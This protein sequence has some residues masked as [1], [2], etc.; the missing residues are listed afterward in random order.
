MHLQ[1]QPPIVDH[2]RQASPLGNAGLLVAFVATCF[3][4]L[5]AV[6]LGLPVTLGG[7]QAQLPEAFLRALGIWWLWALLAPIVFFVA[8]RWHPE[9]VA[10]SRALAA[11]AAGAVVVSMLHSLIYV[12][13]MLALV[14]PGLLPNIE[15]VWQRNLIG[16][17]FGDLVTYGALAAAW[18]AVDYR[19]RQRALRTASAMPVVVPRPEV[20]ALDAEHEPPAK[21]LERITVRSM[22][23]TTIVPVSDIEW[24]EA[25]GDYAMLHCARRRHLASERISALA[26]LLDPARFLRVHRSAIVRVDCIREVRPRTHGDSDIILVDGRIVR[27]SRTYRARVQR[28]LED[29]NLTR[30][31]P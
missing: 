3:G 9:R 2:A 10:L 25:S 8:R 21:W 18:Y 12:P 7:A 15:A 17:I 24:I 31:A 26:R 13:V 14:W 20:P 29:R 5:H 27:S 1:T 6:K 19:R 28:A 30:N 23:R 11:H 22:G 4:V 16:N